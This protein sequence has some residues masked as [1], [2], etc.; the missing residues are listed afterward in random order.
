MVKYILNDLFASLS[1]STRRDI[2]QRL[3]LSELSISQL[4]KT[5][6]MSLPAVSKHLKV[7]EASGLIVKEKRGRQWFVRL[8]PNAFREA[9]EHLQYYEAVLHNRL[10][11]L[12]M[13]LQKKPVAARQKNAQKPPDGKPQEI[14]VTSICEGDPAT[15]WQ[16]YVDPVNIKRWWDLPGAQLL[17]VENDAR[18][19]GSWYFTLRGADD[20]EY[21]LGGKYSVVEYPRRLEYTE[22]A[23]D[24]DKA[25]PQTRVTITFERLPDGKTLLTRKSL[26]TPATHQMNA[27]WLRMIGGG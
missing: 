6:N 9:N 13:F 15:V 27:A 24:P 17:T 7:L 4:A 5:Y 23:G 25:R 14:A 11:S 26:A 1:D 19:G 16:A 18:V 8:T 20:H 2:L 10:D 22:D 12:A 21:V 3:S